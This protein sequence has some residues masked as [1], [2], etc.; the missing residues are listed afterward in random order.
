MST[1]VPPEVAKRHRRSIASLDR[2]RESVAGGVTSTV[3]TAARPVPLYF[4]RGLGTRLWDVDGNEYVDFLLSYGPSILGHASPVVAQAI[5]AQAAR[6]MTFGS[7]HELEIEAAELLTKVV[8]NAD[9]AIF[10]STGSEAVAAAL[11]VVRA[12]T[13]RSLVLKF[14]GHYHGWFDGMFASV[15]NSM[16]TEQAIIEQPVPQTIGSAPGAAADV[17]AVRWNDEDALVAAFDQYGSSIAAVIC[18]PLNVNGGVIPP[19]PGF[20]QLVRSMCTDNGSLLV[21]D[22]VITGFRLALGGAQEFYGVD[23]DMTVFAKALAGGFP[24]SA[25]TGTEAAMEVVSSGRLIHNG[26]FNGNPLGCAAII[27]TVSEL[28][29]DSEATYTRLH[30]LGGQLAAGLADSH[31]DLAVRS[32]GPIS[33]SVMGDPHN[34]VRIQDRAGSDDS[35]QQSFVE[36]LIAWGIHSPGL[37]YVSTEHTTADIEL[38]IAAAQE[39]LALV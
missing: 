5:A 16:G 13:G 10:S 28:A 19:M 23:A 22:E 29:R 21:F 8:P 4:D 11:R 1:E 25:V 26:T 36:G 30:A 31:P 38:A 12:A 3:R 15:G 39:I 33:I 37:W 7:Q 32:V 9:R 35:R 34:V 14:Q 17:I 20:L 18:E 24:I 27:A 2:A 6:G